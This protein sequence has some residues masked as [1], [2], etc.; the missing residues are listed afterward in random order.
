MAKLLRGKS[1]KTE[2]MMRQFHVH[3]LFDKET[4]PK[5]LLTLLFLLLQVL[6][7]IRVLK[8]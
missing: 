4:G 8:Y 7:V 3:Q 2:A 5:A 1:D 6:V